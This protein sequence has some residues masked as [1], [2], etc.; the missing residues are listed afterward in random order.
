MNDAQ[1]AK[2]AAIDQVRDNRPDDY[3]QVL[4]F[5]DELI[6]DKGKY[7]LDCEDGRPL[8]DPA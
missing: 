2:E 8:P 5:L 6:R 3:S 1:K 7:S 4:V